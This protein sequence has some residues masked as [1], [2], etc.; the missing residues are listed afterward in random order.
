MY[1]ERLLTENVRH[2]ASVEQVFAEGLRQVQRWT[3]LDAAAAG[4][5]CLRC[6]ALAGQGRW[7]LKHLAARARL[8]LA[9]DAERPV[10]VEFVLIR[11]APQERLPSSSPR[12]HQGWRILTGGHW[13][14]VPRQALRCQVAGA[15]GGGLESGRSHTGR[16]LLGYGCSIQPGTDGFGIHP[17]QRLRRC[18]GLFDSVSRVTDPLAFLE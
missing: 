17:D 11:H 2:L 8:L 14:G 7:Q 13:E 18:A 16:L 6:L 9:A 4:T 15:R 3:L 5:A 1:L 10:Q 12:R